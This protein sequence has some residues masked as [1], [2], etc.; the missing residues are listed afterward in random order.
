MARAFYKYGSWSIEDLK[1]ELKKQR[2]EMNAEN[3]TPYDKSVCLDKVRDIIKE[4]ERRNR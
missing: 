2:A 4:I 3:A 1:E